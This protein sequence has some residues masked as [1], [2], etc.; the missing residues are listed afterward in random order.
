[1]TRMFARI[2]LPL[3]PALLAVGLTAC[4]GGGATR[5]ANDR[6]FAPRGST[7]FVPGVGC[8]INQALVG[9]RCVNVNNDRF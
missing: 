2:V 3:A 8:G 5:P 4:T 1:M 7:A 9:N 6:I